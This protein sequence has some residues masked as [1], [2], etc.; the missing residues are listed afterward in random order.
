MSSPFDKCSDKQLIILFLFLN[1]SLKNSVWSSSYLTS[2][3]RLSTAFDFSNSSLILFT[4]EKNACFSQSK[5]STIP[6]L[7]RWKFFTKLIFCSSTVLSLAW[8]DSFSR[9]KHSRFQLVLKF[10]EWLFVKSIFY[11]PVELFISAFLVSSFQSLNRSYYQYLKV[12][13][14]EKISI[15]FISYWFHSAQSH[16]TKR[17]SR[18]SLLCF[19]K[20]MHTGLQLILRLR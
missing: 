2:S 16:K 9:N 3:S 7:N 19:F 13:I 1:S 4:S 15:C 18:F 12:F 6:D 5:S 10:T 8:E 17:Q 20:W 14:I 11:E